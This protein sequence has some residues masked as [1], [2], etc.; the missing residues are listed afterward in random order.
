MADHAFQ[1]RLLLIESHGALR[2]D[3]TRA[4]EHIGFIVEAFGRAD[5]AMAS[6]RAPF[7]IGVIDLGARGADLWLAERA[8]SQ[9]T[10]VLVSDP[11]LLSAVDGASLEGAEILYKP[12]SI[13][14]LETRILARLDPCSQAQ[15]GTRDPILETRDPSLI[16]RLARARRLARRAIPVSIEGELGT[17]RRALAEAIHE[18]SPRAGQSLHFLESTE[19]ASVS[20][21]R[22]DD[23]IDEIL[24]E[25]SNGTV[26]LVDPADLPFSTQE[27][28]IRAMRRFEE[29]GPRWL[30]IARIALEQS[31][32]EGRLSLELQ[33]RL[34]AARLVMP[35]F[36]ERERDHRDLCTTAARQVAR[37][38]GEARI[39]IGDEMLAVLSRDGFP[40]N[41][42][43]LESRLRSGLVRA[44]GDPRRITELLNE[45]SGRVSDSRAPLASLHL[46][47]LE[48]D[49]I[50]RALAHWD[51]NRTRA[52]EALGISVRTLR[53]KI[54]EYG[55]R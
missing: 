12:F 30:T 14:T 54:R 40:G 17:G 5:E 39:E 25:M 32:R 1:R 51:G 4:L 47:T 55:L 45:E 53:N 3:L 36:R 52:S 38:L 31:V 8:P 19:L 34:D 21:R 41:R 13:H 20:P 15:S 37:E 16:Q 46:K 28:L 10:I 44:G 27:V 22:Q 23:A 48:R 11:A 33:Y 29:K 26:V 6:A 2:V 24:V 50:V 42:F 18:W 43:G 49:T 9:E 35:P 7:A